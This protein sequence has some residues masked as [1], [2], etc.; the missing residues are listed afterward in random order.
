MFKKGSKLYSIF[1]FKCPQCQEGDFFESH[2]YDLKRIG[3]IH[4][5]CS[6]C[7]L[8]YEKEIGFYYGAMY[9]SYA[10]GVA[11]FVTLWTSFNLFFPWATIYTQLWVIV[12]MTV[13]LSPY[14]YAL[15]KII[16]A[17]LFMHYKSD[18]NEYIAK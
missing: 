14:L 13:V 5:H 15:S 11:L 6:N 10:L 7:N 8:K 12:T 18:P 9:V 4:A 17:N 3:N 16:W 2:P 1:R